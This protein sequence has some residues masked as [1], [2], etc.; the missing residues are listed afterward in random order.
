MQRLG[1][2]L[3]LCFLLYAPVAVH[4]HAHV[5]HMRVGGDPALIRTLAWN[6]S[7]DW[8]AVGWRDGRLAVFAPN[9]GET[10][11]DGVNIMLDSYPVNIEWHPVIPNRFAVSVRE[12]TVTIFDV[13]EDDHLSTVLTLPENYDS[14]PIPLAVRWSS[15]GRWLAALQVFAGVDVWDVESGALHAHYPLPYAFVDLAWRPQEPVLLLTWWEAEAGAALIAWN[16]V[17]DRSGWTLPEPHSLPMRIGWSPDGAQFASAQS[18]GFD[19]YAHVRL[20]A[21]EDGQVL[22]QFSVD[23]AEPAVLWSPNPYLLLS[24]CLSPGT[25]TAIAVWE[26]LTDT[27]SPVATLQLADSD[28]T[29]ALSPDLQLAYGDTDVEIVTLELPER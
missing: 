16:P 11:D 17:D 29:F 14:D 12:G 3:G 4:G 25:Q 7:G 2:L 9:T 6:Q 10:P 8:L 18:G 26:P 15:D 28:C 5:R 23:F 22:E 21:A 1:L 27:R 19:P 13:G 20:H 24:E